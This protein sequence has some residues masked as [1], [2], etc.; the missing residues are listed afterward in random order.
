M[1]PLIVVWPY[2]VVFWIVFFWAFVPEYRIIRRRQ[3]RTATAQDSGSKRV[4]ELGQ[5]AGNFAAFMVAFIVRSAGLPFRTGFFWIGV[6]TLVAGSLLRRHCWR[7]LGTSFTGVVIVKA[8]QT[9]VERG[10][11]RFVRHPSYTAGMI[12]MI[13]LGL[14]LGNWISLVVLLCATGATY[15]Y[16]VRVEERALV[17]TLGDPYRQYMERTRRF[18]PGVF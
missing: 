9:V 2:A 11:Y 6:V 10:A 14:A 5:G 13:G 15:L 4:I 12:M 18:V 7:M 3:E 1:I 8:D 16:R 17:A